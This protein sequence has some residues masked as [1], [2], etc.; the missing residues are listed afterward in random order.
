MSIE[1]LG[2]LLREIPAGRISNQ[3][4]QQILKEL[5]E[6]WDEFSGS[7]ETKMMIH[8]IVRDEGPEEMTWSPPTLSF[9]ILRHGSYVNG[10]KRAEKQQ[11]SLNL[12]TK[13]A[14][15]QI[16]GYRNIEPNQARLNTKALATSIKEAVERGRSSGAKPT[17]L[18]WK[19]DDLV[20]ISRSAIIP[21]TAAKQTVTSRRK[22]FKVELEAEMKGIGWDPVIGKRTLHFKRAKQTD[23]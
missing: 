18:Q 14:T 20:E 1:R 11:W 15:S 6:S 3:H 16:I 2:A 8:K 22:R 13:D 7:S 4:V 12:D 5:C 21:D 23:A 19:T 10:S 9:V 17:G